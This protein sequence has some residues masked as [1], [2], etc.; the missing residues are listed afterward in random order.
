MAAVS[1][2]NAKKKYGR[3]VAATEPSDEEEEEEQQQLQSITARTRVRPYMRAI[4][5]GDDLADRHISWCKTCYTRG[6]QMCFLI[7]LGVVCVGIFFI[8]K[9]GTEI[10]WGAVMRR[11]L[12]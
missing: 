12:G 11:A 7:T 3:Y 1:R 4:L 6:C 2:N 10:L 9:T 5:P 8:L